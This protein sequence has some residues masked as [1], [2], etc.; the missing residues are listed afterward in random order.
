METLVLDDKK[1]Y[2]FEKV[3]TENFKTEKNRKDYFK[4]KLA[5][6][7][8]GTPFAFLCYEIPVATFEDIAT[9]ELAKEEPG[10]ENTDGGQQE[11]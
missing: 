11:T 5:L 3:N 7:Q 4:G 2:V 8:I 9:E 10:K 6:Q 1:Y